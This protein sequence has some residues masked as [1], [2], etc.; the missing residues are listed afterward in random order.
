[1]GGYAGLEF[2]LRLHFDSL[3]DAVGQQR[4]R[5]SMIK[6][7]DVD[8]LLAEV[9][10]RFMYLRNCLSYPADVVCEFSNCVL[11]RRDSS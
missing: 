8:V 1:M 9:K 11:C 4:C 2:V 6:G 7:M 3:H 5:F 10:L